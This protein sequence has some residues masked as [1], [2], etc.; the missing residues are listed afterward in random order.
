MY[1]CYCERCHKWFNL[2]DEYDE[3]RI[4]VK[5]DGRN[6]ESRPFCKECGKKIHET[7]NGMLN[8]SEDSTDA[9]D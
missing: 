7:I 5:T 4:I 1:L 8:E 9:T 6:Y 2:N 3:M